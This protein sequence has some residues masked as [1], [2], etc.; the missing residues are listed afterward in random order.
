MVVS[1][2]GLRN[3][4]GERGLLRE[5]T[6]VTSARADEHSILLMLP[7]DAFRAM[8]EKHEAAKRFFNRARAPRPRG[9]DLATSKVETFMAGKP[10]TCPADTD[11]QA[12]AL[13]MRDNRISSICITD[14]KA[15]KGIAT[16]RDL[17]GKVLAEALPVTTP[18]EQVMTA[19][20]ITLEPSA[21]GSDVLHLM[22]ERRIGHVP[23]TKGASWSAS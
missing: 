2:L 14:G 8:N 20:P 17:T 18:I 13:L 21:I 5:G 9:T 12:A 15:L 23:I 16:T 11:V 6:A 3:S 1:H 10:V 7:A 19:D 22:M 4:F